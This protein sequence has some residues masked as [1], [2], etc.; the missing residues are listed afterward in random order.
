MGCYKPM[1]IWQEYEKYQYVF[2]LGC[3][4]HEAYVPLST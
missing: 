3:I 2:T 4:G 1:T